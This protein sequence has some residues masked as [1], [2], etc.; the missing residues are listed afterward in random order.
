MEQLI[1]FLTV[2]PA[3]MAFLVAA[4][5]YDEKHVAVGQNFMPAEV[6]TYAD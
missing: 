3:G 6:S 4:W 1:Y 2:F 5:C